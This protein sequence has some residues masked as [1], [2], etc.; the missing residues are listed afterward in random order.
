[1]IKK[2]LLS[3]SVKYATVL[4]YAGRM[5]GSVMNA[6]IKRLNNKCFCLSIPIVAILQ[7]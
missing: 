1:M 3:V 2:G 6:S 4:C 5:K 7:Q